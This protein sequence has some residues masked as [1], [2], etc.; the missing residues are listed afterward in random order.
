M[1]NTEAP[2]YF[3]HTADTYISLFF[4][5]FLLVLSVGVPGHHV[6]SRCIYGLR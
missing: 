3:T 1:S 4:E 6:Y 5:T 2:N